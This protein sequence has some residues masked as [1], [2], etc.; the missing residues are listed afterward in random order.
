MVNSEINVSMQEV[1]AA[2][3]V[4]I[5]VSGVRITKMRMWLGMQIISLGARIIGFGHIE[6]THV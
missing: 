6:V 5:N 3:T 1:L 2:H 4:T